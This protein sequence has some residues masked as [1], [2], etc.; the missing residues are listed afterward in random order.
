MTKLDW[1][2]FKPY[3]A[4][5]KEYFL[6]VVM[7]GSGDGKSSAVATLKGNTAFVYD[8]DDEDHG[9]S[10]A[11]TNK[12]DGTTITPIDLSLCLETGKKLS[13]PDEKLGQW[14]ALV[15]DPKGIAASFDNFAIDG[16]KTLE[17]IFINSEECKR[18]CLTAKGAHDQWAVFRLSK[19]F[20]A[21]VFVKLNAINKEDVNVIA[22][23][24]GNYTQKENEDVKTFKPVLKGVGVVEDILAKM[25]D[26]LLV[27]KQ[28]RKH[29]FT[30]D[31][32]AEKA[33][34]AKSIDCSPRLRPLGYNQ[35][36]DQMSADLEKVMMLKNGSAVYNAETGKVEKPKSK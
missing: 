10:Y 2:K 21:E 9:P 3:K 16:L 25:P 15:A 4:P 5:S 24:L 11:N 13:T 19:E 33:S 28:G 35:I 20:F 22:T 12:A 18:Q 17:S 32:T 1:N 27:L 6:G 30:F 14:R 7:G 29:I 31:T 36:P 34:A 23:C 26:R 8:S